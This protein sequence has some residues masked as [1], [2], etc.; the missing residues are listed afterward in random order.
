MSATL[1]DTASQSSYRLLYIEDNPT[2]QKL[3]EDI[4]DDYPHVQLQ[5]V[6]SAELGLEIMRY[7][8]PDLVLIDINLPGMNGYRALEI[9]RHDAQLK[10]LPVI[11]LS[12]NAMERDIA[13]GLEAGFADYLTKPIDLDKLSA[14]LS[15]YLAVAPAH[16]PRMAP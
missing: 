7:S 13:R 9:I 15:H 3:M 2:N 1:G 10:H 5:T 16:S 11:A 6:S 12:A 4:V 8:P 14:T